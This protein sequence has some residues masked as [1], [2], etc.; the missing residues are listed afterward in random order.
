MAVHIRQ[1]AGPALLQRTPEVL[2]Q[3]LWNEFPGPTGSEF[4]TAYRHCPAAEHRFANR[5][6]PDHQRW[7]EVHVYPAAAG[8]AVYFR[9]VTA[10]KQA[11]AE[12][13]PLTATSEQQRRIYETAL[14][15]SADFNYIFDRQGRFIYVNK[16]LL[17][18][19]GKRLHEALGRNFFELGYP[20][21]DAQRL[22][23]QIQQVIATRGRP[24]RSTLRLALGGRITNTSS[25]RCWPPTARSRP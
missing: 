4:E 14:S 11:E 6:V 1:F 15:N 3:E 9:D 10:R 18:L 21:D 13:A 16:A 22:Q 23:R 19:W 8:I 2:G 24:R 7:Y 17:D 12:S 5:L 20:P 25:C